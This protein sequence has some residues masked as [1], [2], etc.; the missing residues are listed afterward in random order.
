[1]LVRILLPFLSTVIMA[2]G[3]TGMLGGYA[4]SDISVHA[5]QDARFDKLMKLDAIAASL[6]TASYSHNRQAAYSH[7]LKLRRYMEDEM[8]HGYG[9]E[10]GW[11]LLNEDA[12]NV[13]RALTEGQADMS[14]LDNVARIRLAVDAMAR[15][16]RALW[17]PYEQL[18]RDDVSSIRQAWHRGDG[19]EGAAAAAMLQRM[20]GHAIRIETAANMAGQQLRMRELMERI[21]YGNRVLS[22]MNA[23]GAGMWTISNREVERTLQTMENVISAIYSGDDGTSYPAI[24]SPAEGTPIRWIF[25]IGT[26]ISAVLTYAGWRKYRSRPYGIKPLP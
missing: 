26:L 24:A 23:H 10:E 12:D 15:P 8:I 21:Q 19:A 20:H 4:A 2:L 18:L 7:L 6:Y 5:G 14:W 25:M 13:E 9:A 16:D 17:R 11:I 1:M 22:T 3:A